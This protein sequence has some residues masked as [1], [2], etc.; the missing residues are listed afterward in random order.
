MFLF[1]NIIVAMEAFFPLATI[2]FDKCYS[3]TDKRQCSL[4]HRMCLPGGDKEVALNDFGIVVAARSA[5]INGYC[6]K[7]IVRKQAGFAM[8]PTHC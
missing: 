5:D 7:I 8:R 4:T 1:K 3:P 6:G 2:I